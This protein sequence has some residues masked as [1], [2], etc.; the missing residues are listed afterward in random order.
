MA[1]ALDVADLDFD[2]PDD[3]AATRPI[4][5]RGEGRA[6]DDGRLLVNDGDDHVDARFADLPAFLDPGDLLVVNRSATLPASLPASGP[7]GEFV[8]NLSTDYGGLWLAEPRRSHAQPGPLPLGPGDRFTAA[9]LGARVVARYPGIPRL[10]FVRF[11]G[12]VY[13]AM[14]ERGRPIRYGYAA[15]AFPLDD[16]QTTFAT[17]PGSAEMPSAGRP[18]TGRTIAALSEAGVGITPVTLHAGVSSIEVEPGTDWRE[19]L[20][21]EPFAVSAAT[22]DAIEGT[23]TAGGRVVAV[24]TTVVRALEST[25]RD[26][27]IRAAK[28]FTRRVVEPDR[29]ILAVDAL[30]T[31][32]HDPR[33][34]HLAM[35]YAIAGERRVRAAYDRAVVDGYRW[36]EF[37]DSHLLFAEE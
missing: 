26:G 15:E 22:A 35:L 36:H 33:T 2:R 8:L 10:L 32:F 25:V 29:G 17:V 4:E 37:G 6:R 9:G 11:V 20:F 1:A 24:G 23:R 34:T 13:R 12:D 27:R 16:Y 18:F 7:P 21:P 14:D 5:R 31:G 30:L 19:T 28:G 3:R